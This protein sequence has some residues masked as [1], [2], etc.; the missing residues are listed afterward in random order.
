M[1]RAERIFVASALCLCSLLAWKTLD[2][3]RWGVEFCRWEQQQKKKA[4]Y[5]KPVKLY[6]CDPNQ[7]ANPIIIRVHTR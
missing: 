2:A 3:V 1:K 7:W 4:P 5:T 6:V